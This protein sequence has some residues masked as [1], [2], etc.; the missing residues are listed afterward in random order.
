MRKMIESLNIGGRLVSTSSYFDDLNP[1]DN[2][3]W[4]KIPDATVSETRLAIDAAKEAFPAWSSLPFTK[5]AHYMHKVADV[6]VS[7]QTEI[8]SALQ[9]ESGSWFGKGMF[10]SGY[11]SEVF[12]AAAA[13]GYQ[14][15][16]EVMPSEHGKLSMAIRSPMGVISVISPWN[17]PALLTS[18][19][20]A[21]ALAAGNTVVLKPSEETP[22]TGGL[23]F[24][25]IFQ[26]A[27]IPEGVLNVITCSREQV[28]SVGNELVENPLVK[29]VSFTG[30]T[31]VGRQIAARAG[32]HL[33]KCCVELG[34]KDSL[35]ILDDADMERAVG[36][37]NFGSF[38]HQGQICM[39][40]EKVLVH[41]AIFD[42][43]LSQFS[44]RASQLKVGDPCKDN[45]NVIGPLINDAQVTRVKEQLDDALAKGAKLVTGGNVDGRFVEPTILTHVTPQMKI[46]NDETFG[47][48]VPVI[49]FSCDEE[50][51]AI[52]N[53]TEYGL[54]SGIISQDENRAL[55][56]ARRLETGMCHV[57]CSSVNDEPHVPF[58]GAKS[59]GLGRHGGRWSTETFTD[60]RWITLERGG[61]GFPPVF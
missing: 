1:V 31:A 45:A 44:T 46:Y 25:E 15:V 9:Q 51:I 60:T 61:R 20:I 33:K 27:G 2:S 21:F 10:E 40:V 36:A 53:N 24:T 52:A 38:M 5:R 48:V 11:I 19:G 30:S 4:A 13:M 12:R 6:I 32:A 57:N 18:R 39:S 56:I 8:V 50:A 17:F 7:R 28:A 26:E 29:G 34:G 47:P 16:G 54:S 22:Y 14:S 55:D 59:S 35:I 3:V 43:F 23:L 42:S 49:P 41:Q 58:G 37:A